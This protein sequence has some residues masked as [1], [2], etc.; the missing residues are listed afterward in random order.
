MSRATSNRFGN[1]VMYR[2]VLAQ[3]LLLLAIFVYASF[4]LGADAG[5]QGWAA[6]AVLWLMK[7]S[8]LLL[9]L[10]GV[11]LGKARSYLWLCFILLMYFLALVLKLF[12]VTGA[13]Y[14]YA[15]LT[16]VVTLFITSMMAARWQT[17]PIE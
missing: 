5:P 14:D 9:V 13:W 16:L 15:G 11:V 1:A 12:S 2:L 6:K 7:I 10:P 17:A 8:G 3:Y 4:F